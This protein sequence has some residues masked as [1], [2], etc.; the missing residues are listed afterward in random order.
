[1]GILVLGVSTRAIAES[2]VRSGRRIVT[3][4][5]FGDQD[6][7]RLVEN[8]SLREFRLP[9]TALGLAE[10]ARRVKA[11]AVVY[12]AN[13]ENHPG[14]VSQLA[15][16]RELLGNAPQVLAEVRDWRVL[17]Q[18]CLEA[19]IACPPTLL[20]GE[21]AWASPSVRWLSKPMRGGGGRGVRRWDGQPLDDSHVLQRQVEGRAAS[22]AFVADGREGR[23]IGVT[24]QLLGQAELGASG[25]VWCGNLLPLDLDPSEGPSFL[26]RIERMV[27]RLTRRFGLRGA[28]GADFVI[29]RGP[30]GALCPF[31]VE[32]NPRY[33]A[34][35]ELAERAFGMNVFSLHLEGV[36]GR[37]PDF[38]L[39]E[40]LG[41]PGFS[42]KGIVYARQTGSVPDTEQWIERGIRDVPFPG[43]RIEAGHPICTVFARGEDRQA[44]LDDLFEQA[45]AV[46]EEVE[47]GRVGAPWA[48]NSR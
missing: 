34:S 13:L 3:V 32:V 40:H 21:E 26:R 38:C 41:Q 33:S 10:A 17:R 28:N 47:V 20:P 2:A 44:C 4:D 23:V 15:L 18:F 25:F 9:L 22:V 8:Y 29:G 30:D 1:M 6:Q 48:S 27:S 14:I 7:K 5:Y 16:E 11:D 12:I 39:A 19:D 46:H 36:A 43:Q 24:E 31:L 35:M 45:A 37:L 42:G